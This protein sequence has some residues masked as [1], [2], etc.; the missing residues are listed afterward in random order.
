MDRSNDKRDIC[1]LL[2]TFVVPLKVM[3]KLFVVLVKLRLKVPLKVFVLVLKVMLS[4]ISM[5]SKGRKVVFRLFIG[6]FSRCCMV[7]SSWCLI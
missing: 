7:F 2:K 3:L 4:A 5:G 6:V 1:C